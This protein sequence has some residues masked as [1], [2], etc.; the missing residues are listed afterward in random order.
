VKL[1]PPKALAPTTP[2]TPSKTP[3]APTAPPTTPTTPTAPP[4]TPTTTTPTHKDFFER[5]GDAVAG[6]F[7]GDA[8]A[9]SGENMNRNEG[10]RTW[11][12][13]VGEFLT[14]DNNKDRLKGLKDIALGEAK[15]LVQTPVDAFL[16]RGGRAVSG[17]QTLAGIEPV[18]RGLSGDE[19]AALR[20]VYGNSVDYSKIRIKEGDAGLLTTSGRPFA[21]GNTIYMPPGSLPVSQHLDTLVHE[22]GHVWQFQH[23]GTDYMSEALYAQNLGDGYDWQ[24]GVDSGKSWGNLNPEQ[25]A[26]LISSAYAAGYFDNPGNGYNVGGKDYTAYLQKA[27]AEVQA[28]RGAP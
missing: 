9:S 11:A 22:T 7:S 12:T 26:Q 13:G 17:V 2:P 21:H 28:G 23:G 16:M 15:I 25:Q 3:T 4:T 14:A 1:P 20:K 24:R 19:T 6:W 5:A 27:L 18:S 10:L 8:A